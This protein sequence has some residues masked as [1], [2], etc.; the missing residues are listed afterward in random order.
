MQATTAGDFPILRKDD[1]SAPDYDTLRAE[2]DLHRELDGLLAMRGGRLNIAYEAVRHHVEDGRGDR[3]AIRFL[4][5]S[6]PPRDF[7]YSDLDRLSDR[8]AA[9]LRAH[10][11][12]HG[13]TVFSLLGR[14]P[15]LYAAIL[16]TWKAGCVFSPLFSAFGPEPVRARMT[17]GDARVLVT[18]ETFYRRK[19]MTWRDEM[20]GLSLVLLAGGGDDL[21]AGTLDLEAAL[22]DAGGEG[23]EI[24]ATGPEDPALLH[25]TS[26]TTGK[27]KGAVHVHAAVVVHRMTARAVL[28]LHGADTYWC[29]AD[30]GW[31]TG[32][33]YGIVAPLVSGAPMIVDEAEFDAERWYTIL[34]REGVTVWYTAPTAI[35]M[36]MKLGEDVARG[37]DLSRLRFL[38]SV[39]EPLNPEAV[40]WS[41]R[42]FGKPFHDNWWQTETGGIMIANYA[43]MDVKP[44]SMGK[45]VPGIEAAVVSRE[46]ERV[47]PVTTPDT[48]GELALKAGWP[49]MFRRYLNEPERTAKCFADGW[50]LTGDLAMRDGD[51][52]FW[53]VGRADDVIKSSGHLIGPFEVES[54]LMEHP[55]VAE[56]GVIGLPDPVAGEVV[57]A[58]VS[59]K[60][61]H[62]PSEETKRDILGHARKR[63]GRAVAPRDIAFR[64]TLPRTRSGKIMRRLL[65]ARELGLPEGDTSTLEG[66]A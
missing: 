10:G 5:A 49:S 64:D 43:G 30:P 31:V 12:A 32:T 21:P 48:S 40:V 60:P 65:K 34:E 46:G 36:L 14:G 56:A 26:G 8:F 55:A 18:T 41:Q 11:I 27:P 13:S 63:L 59:L 24:A 16:G 50:Y 62:E 66:G 3:R 20:P 15:A 9:I 35:R 4:P 2:V 17:I 23:A 45:P 25:F 52:Y 33:S 44:G 39:G 58:F 7:T 6:G 19:V 37:H 28:N 1:P 42:V 53:F 38:A 22:E 47:T 29:T 51:G 57:K 54:I 61:G